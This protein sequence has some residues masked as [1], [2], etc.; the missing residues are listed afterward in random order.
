M[1]QINLHLPRGGRGL[2]T[3][4]F[5]QSEL[6]ILC[7]QCNCKIG[8]NFLRQLSSSQHSRLTKVVVFKKFFD[9]YLFGFLVY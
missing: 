1:C 3:N 9:I 5:K 8:L 4:D 2:L 6:V 7:L